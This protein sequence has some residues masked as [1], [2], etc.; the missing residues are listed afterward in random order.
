MDQC[1]TGSSLSEFIPLLSSTHNSRTLNWT[2][3]DSIMSCEELRKLDF[4]ARLLL[5]RISLNAT[6]SL[7]CSDEWTEGIFFCCNPVSFFSVNGKQTMQHQISR[8]AEQSEIEA[9]SHSDSRLG[10][11]ACGSPSSFEG[12]LA[13]VVDTR[14]PCPKLI[15]SCLSGTYVLN[16]S[17]RLGVSGDLS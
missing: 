15:F 3:F 16:V 14:S 1:R 9:K 6:P 11:R 17:L 5:A 13:D 7:Y 4:A 2:N 8:S 12:G 10:Y